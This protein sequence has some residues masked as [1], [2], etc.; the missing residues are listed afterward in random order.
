MNKKDLA[1]KAEEVAACCCVDVGTVI[2]NSDLT[3]SFSQKYPSQEMAQ[4]A[5]N[6]LTEKANS[7]TQTECKIES[8]ITKTADGYE[9]TAHFTFECQAETMIFQLATR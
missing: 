4:D 9:L 8:K 1:C 7:S 5:L 2:D 6:Y 3:V